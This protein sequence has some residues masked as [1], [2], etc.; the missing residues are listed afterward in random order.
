M[1]LLTQIGRFADNVVATVFYGRNKGGSLL[2]GNKL[3]MVA[4][5][6]SVG[7][8]Y[9]LQTEIALYLAF[10][11]LAIVSLDGVPASSIFD[12]KSFHPTTLDGHDFLLLVAHESF[13]LLDVLVVQL[14]QVVL[15]ILLEVFRQSVLDG[16]LQ[17]LLDFLT[18]VAHLN[19]SL[20]GY[21]VALLYQFLTALTCRLRNA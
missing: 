3:H 18:H 13:Q 4:H 7:A 19:L 1:A 10:N 17:L 16:L 12:D 21:L 14:L 20:L 11:K 2:I 6:H 9:S 15:S 5:S 8:A